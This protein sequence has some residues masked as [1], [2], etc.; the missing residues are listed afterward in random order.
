MTSRRR[1]ASCLRFSGPDSAIQADFIC[2][3][4]QSLESP[5]SEKVSALFCAA[6]VVAVVP[7]KEKSR[8]TSSEIM[9]RLFFAQS[10]ASCDCSDAFA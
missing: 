3:R 9:A 10:A 8:N 2:G 1:R 7:S 6:K 5:L 4:P